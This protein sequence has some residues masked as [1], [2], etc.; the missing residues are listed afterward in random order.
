MQIGKHDVNQ[1]VFHTFDTTDRTHLTFVVPPAGLQRDL[2]FA[3]E[4][5][6]SVDLLVFAVNSSSPSPMIDEVYAARIS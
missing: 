4:L 5:A 3:L 2:F 6:R 1:T